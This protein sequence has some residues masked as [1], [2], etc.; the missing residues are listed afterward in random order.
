MLDPQATKRRDAQ[1]RVRLFG[2]LASC[3]EIPADGGADDVPAF[4]AVRVPIRPVALSVAAFAAACAGT[5]GGLLLIGGVVL[6]SSP[7]SP[8]N[9]AI[10]DLEK[11]S[12]MKGLVDHRHTQLVQLASL[13]RQNNDR[14][15]ACQPACASAVEELLPLR[16]L[17]S[18]IQEDTSR[19]F[20]LR[21]CLLDP[22]DRL[23]TS[24]NTHDVVPQQ[25]ECATEPV[26]DAGAALDEQVEFL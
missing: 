22:R 19:W 13:R 11:S 7:P 3:G 1:K 8:R 12:D 23:L 4:C 24:G 6:H 20:T 14:E 2:R 15:T 9:E 26:L 25:R 18:E 21:A 10:E 17:T 5:E 16:G